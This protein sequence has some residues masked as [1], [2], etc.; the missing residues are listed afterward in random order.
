M[1]SVLESD[2]QR[3]LRRATQR[4]PTSNRSLVGDTHRCMS[5]CD[6]YVSIDGWI[7][8]S[9]EGRRVRHRAPASDPGA[10]NSRPL[11]PLPVLEHEAKSVRRWR[12]GG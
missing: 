9:P 8:P 2:G 7:A 1:S 11:Q 12:R 4:M 3:R 6:P 10:E 5:A